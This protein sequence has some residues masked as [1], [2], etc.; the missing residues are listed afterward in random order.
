VA[1]P[2]RRSA[3]GGEARGPVWFAGV[4]QNLPHG[5]RLVEEGDTAYCGETERAG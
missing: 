3:R 5:I 4:I 1:Q 2:Q